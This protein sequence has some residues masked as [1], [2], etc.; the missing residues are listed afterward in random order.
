MNALGKDFTNLQYFVPYEADENG[1]EALTNFLSFN[2][3][4]CTSECKKCDVGIWTIRIHRYH[5]TLVKVESNLQCS[6]IFHST[7]VHR[8]VLLVTLIPCREK[9]FKSLERH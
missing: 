3:F 6:R 9:S 8:T 2:L 7:C 1:V 5:C 4:G